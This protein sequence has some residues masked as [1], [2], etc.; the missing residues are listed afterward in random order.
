VVPKGGTIYQ[1]YSIK[2]IV[3]HEKTRFL[4]NNIL[5]WKDHKKILQELVQKQIYCCFYQGLDAR[6]LDEENAELLGA[7]KYDGD[8]IFAFDRLGDETLLT[9]KMQL[10]RKN[11]SLGKIKFFIYCH[12]GVE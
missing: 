12:P 10:I 4:D 8:R 7:M 9:R 6:L 2:D 11:M 3:K 5:A 1:E